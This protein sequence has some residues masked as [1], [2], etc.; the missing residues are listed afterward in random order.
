L[1]YSQ[2]HGLNL[3]VETLLYVW[4]DILTSDNLLIHFKG[5]ILVIKLLYYIKKRI[6]LVDK[7]WI[8]LSG[9]KL[10]SLLDGQRFDPE[11]FCIT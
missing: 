9:K 2:N 4:V 10:E 11:L 1:R 6:L 3:W 7:K 8:S 5:K